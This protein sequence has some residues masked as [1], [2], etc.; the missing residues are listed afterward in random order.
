MD[1]QREVMYRE[2][3]HHKTLSICQQ[4]RKEDIKK[5]NDKSQAIMWMGWSDHKL[6]H[7]NVFSF[8]LNV[9]QYTD[10]NEMAKFPSTPLAENFVQA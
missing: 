3:I 1:C 6:R 10:G 4:I 8:V 2:I 9:K 5:K 7:R